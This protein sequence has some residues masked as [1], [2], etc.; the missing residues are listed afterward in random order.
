MSHT[1]AWYRSEDNP[2]GGDWA[3]C[4]ELKYCWGTFVLGGEIKYCVG[5][6][7]AVW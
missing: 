1:N 7:K 4:G 5:N 3:M 2:P 6:L